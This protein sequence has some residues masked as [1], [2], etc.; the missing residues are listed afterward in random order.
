MDVQTRKKYRS[1]S[2]V[3]CL[4]SPWWGHYFS[5]KD[6]LNLSSSL[7]SS[8]LLLSPGVQEQLINCACRSDYWD[9]T[10]SQLRSW[11]RLMCRLNG[12]KATGPRVVARQFPA[13]E[14]AVWKL[15]TAPPLLPSSNPF[16]HLATAR[17]R[18]HSRH[19]PACCLSHKAFYWLKG[20]LSIRH[21]RSK[22]DFSYG[23]M[24]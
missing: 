22:T 16:P 20:N 1:S 13:Q 19:S 10:I 9:A 6:R 21:G 15:M 24:N 14:S 3:R 17:S 12:D 11:T 8:P 5:N 2:S 4:S 18:S 7:F 23:R